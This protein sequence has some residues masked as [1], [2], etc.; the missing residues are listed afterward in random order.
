M[1]I[2]DFCALRLLTTTKFLIAAAEAEFRV[3][4]IVTS[5]RL[6]RSGPPMTA[7]VRGLRRS[8][9]PACGAVLL[10]GRPGV[11]SGHP[12]MHGPPVCLVL[13]PELAGQHG[14]LVEAHCGRPDAPGDRGVLQ[15]AR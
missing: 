15:H 10:A 12:G 4:G 13:G 11:Q 5:R 1:P 14:F 3:A 7:G 6:T 8:A 9:S 2:R